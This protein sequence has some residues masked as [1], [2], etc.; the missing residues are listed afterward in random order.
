M[1][2]T[3]VLPTLNEAGNIPTLVEQ[4]WAL[5]PGTPIVV[6]DD[7]SRDGTRDIVLAL[8]KAGQPIQ[9]IARAGKPCLTDS[10]WEGI[11]AARTDYVAWMD[12][13]LSH[14][15]RLLPAL[16]EAA[17]RSGCA[18]AT[19]YAP[20]GRHKKGSKDTPD[21]V[22]AVVLSGVLNVLVRT[23]L[24]L[25]V[26]DYTSGFIVCRRDI[27]A[28]HRLVGDYGEYF[29]ELVY[30][31]TRSGVDI[32]EI[33]YESPPRQWGE[34]KTGSSLWLLFRRGLK[35]LWLTLRLHFPRS[36]FGSLSLRQEPRKPS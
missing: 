12:A 20:G 15:P 13:D 29:I 36:L 30:Y 17:E 7:G 4:I 2:L 19:R 21:S 9:L 1:S 24:R 32:V 22:F 5:L 25:N 23:V 34:S 3:V 14:P 35:Y 10:I 31:L 8:V 33:P 6:A 11:E 16:Y 27:L 26:T 28:A 18:I